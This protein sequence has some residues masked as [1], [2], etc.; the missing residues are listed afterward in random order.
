MS[1]GRLTA[2][3]ARFCESYW[4]CRNASLAYREAYSSEGCAAATIHRKAAELMKNGK[5][6]ARLAEL[7]AIA[8]AEFR[9]LA[10]QVIEEVAAIAFTDIAD[11]FDARGHLRP[12]AELPRPARAAISSFKLRGSGETVAVTMADKLKALALLAQLVG[13]GSVPEG[14]GS[15]LGALSDDDLEAEL[16]R[17]EGR[18][19][20]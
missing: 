8:N 1:H 5:V 13:A 9:H 18:T 16:A 19:G 3:Q 12:L 17:L 11:F 10:R 6:T 4:R 15:D 14:S 2:A 7:Q 20:Q